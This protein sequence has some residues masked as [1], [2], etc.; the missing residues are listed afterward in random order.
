MFQ[1]WSMLEL[2]PDLKSD[3]PL[4]DDEKLRVLCDYVRADS[5]SLIDC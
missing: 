1:Y 2:I 3:L 5:L 4:L